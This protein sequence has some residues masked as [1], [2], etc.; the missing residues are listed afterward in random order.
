VY[1]L[2]LGSGK[3][4]WEWEA[5]AALAASPAIGEG[6]LVIGDADGGIHAFGPA[7]RAK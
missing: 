7:Q 2:D 5:G 4:V 6:R 3:K 1:G